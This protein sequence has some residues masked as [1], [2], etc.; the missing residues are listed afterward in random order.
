MIVAT[1]RAL[2]Y[3]GGAEKDALGAE[4]LEA[5]E[6]GLPNLLRHADNI[7]N[8]FGL[9]CVVAVNAFPTD[10]EA[11]LALVA[12]KCAA[13]GVKA[14][15]SDVWAR[16]GAGGEAL[17]AE[18]VRLCEE[19]N[20]F[21]FAYDL[22]GTIEE[23]LDALCRNVYRADGA[24]LTPE[25]KKQAA[26]AHGARLRGAAGVRC[27][28]AVQLFGRRGKT[29]C[30]GGLHRDGAGDPC[31]G[32][33]G[34]SRRAHGQ[35]YDDAG[36]AEVARRR[37]DRRGRKRRH[38]GDVLRMEMLRKSVNDF[39][40]SLASKASVPGGGSASALAGSLAAALGGMVGELTVG[41]EKYAA[42]EPILRELLDEA[43]TL[44]GRL[45][46]C[47]EKDAAAL[48][49]LAKAYAIPKGDPQRAETL[50][51]C[52]TAAAAPPMEVLELTGRTVELLRGF[53][54]MGSPIAVSDA[55]VGAALALAALRGAEINVRVNTRLM[56]DR[57]RAAAL[58]AK[59]HALVDKYARQAEKIYNDV[60]GRLAR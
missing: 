53:A 38:Y 41:K 32:G 19:K 28:N 29:R 2:K 17:A 14:V 44:R 24:V 35:Y 47:V 48:A 49:P 34:L 42:V 33:R 50:E 13:L 60:Y 1:V 45:L 56:Q 12:E 55:A 6:K 15:R 43:E 26:R 3:H 36:S 7:K 25:A 23:R 39:T 52:L 11:E 37:A 40:A 18:V 27:Q 57:A 31:L 54:D 16:G 4:N 22:D 58:D 9:P 30:A 46:D 10:T 59:A 5:L 8:V 20:E 21:R 51:A